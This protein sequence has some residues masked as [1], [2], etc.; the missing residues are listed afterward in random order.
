VFVAALANGVVYYALLARGAIRSSVSLP[1]SLL[2]AASMLLIVTRIN[3]SESRRSR[4]PRRR[5]RE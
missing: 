3:R 5:D 2:I 1:L 4:R